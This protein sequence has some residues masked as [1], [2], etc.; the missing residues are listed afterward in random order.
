MVLLPL[1][2]SRPTGLSRC[3]RAAGNRV[4]DDL[5][6]L[7]KT[8]RGVQLLRGIVVGIDAQQDMS[9][10]RSDGD[11]HDAGHQQFADALP[12]KRFGYEYILN[13][14]HFAH[15]QKAGKSGRLSV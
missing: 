15:I 12:S 9:E 7:V 6:N 8:E 5:S 11:F 2:E 14:A 3:V 13:A 1:R 10:E 4:T